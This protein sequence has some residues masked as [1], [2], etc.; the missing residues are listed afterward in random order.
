MKYA[1][2]HTLIEEAKKDSK[3]MVLT[4]DVGFTVFEQFQ[5]ELPK[6]FINV[7]AAE[8]NLIGVAAGLG[9]TGYTVFAYGIATFATM[10]PFEFI[11]NDIAATN[12]S[13]IVVGTGA[14][15]CYHEAQ[16]THHAVE[17]IAL[18]RMIPNMTVV[19]PADPT[20][21]V[22][23]TRTL[24][25]RRKPAYLRLGKRGEPVLYIKPP[26][27]TLGKASVLRHGND[28]AIIATGNI[29]YNCL[30]ASE[31]LRE[32]HIDAE[33]VSMHTVKPL[34]GDYLHNAAKRYP[35]IVTVEE[36][37]TAGGL[38]GA[39]SELVSESSPVRVLHMG[40]TD[41]FIHEVGSQEYL[42]EQVG[43]TPE[44][45]AKNIRTALKQV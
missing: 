38:G 11:R 42:R 24:A 25:H 4:A 1:F 2:I 33:V 30:K 26:K 15:L 40:I 31:L 39:V 7:G 3:I 44:Q 17:D 36:H 43:L 14:G 37:L 13:V 22:W 10:R 6:Q 34:D 32:L 9:L 19:C 41:R 5:K 45:I 18:M 20:E 27:L 29:V 28:C 21:A 35:L 23:A 16:L 12:A 8:Q